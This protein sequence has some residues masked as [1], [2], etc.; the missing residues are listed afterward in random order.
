MV[1]KL[2]RL[3]LS[4]EYSR[5]PIRRSDI[6]NKVMGES[7]QF[8]LVFDQAQKV[9]TET[10]GMMLTELPVREKVTI[11]QRRG[12]FTFPVLLKFGRRDGA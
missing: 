9:L 8:K 6:S 1:K 11:Q 12:E 3:A 7:R 10:F 4:S 2:V 5:Q